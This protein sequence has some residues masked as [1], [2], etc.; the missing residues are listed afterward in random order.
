MSEQNEALEL[1]RKWWEYSGGNPWTGDRIL[2]TCFFCS[3]SSNYGHD[4]NCFY[5]E[6]AQ[7]LG[8]EPVPCVWPSS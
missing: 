8:K 2:D 7:L 1:W 6:V 3:A 5:L 4:A